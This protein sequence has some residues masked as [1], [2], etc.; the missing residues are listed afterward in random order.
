MF[1]HITIRASDRAAAERFYDTVLAP[2]AID[3][4]ALVRSATFSGWDDFAVTQ[5]DG[6]DDATTRLHVAFIARTQAEVHAFWEAGTA[7]GY[8]DDGAP[9][10][11][12]AYADDYYAA[13]LRDPDGNGIEAVYRD[14]PRRAEGIIDH[15]RLRVTDVSR[16]ADVYRR[17]AQV[18]GAEVRR[19]SPEM[20]LLA[21]A[22]GG[23]FS[24]IAD[25]PTR[26]AHIAFAADADAV[27]RFRQE[28]AAAGATASVL[29]PDGNRVEVADSRI[30][31][32]RS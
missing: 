19:D 17:V 5:A 26:N 27:A 29:D 12:P 2:L 20:L 6:P 9:G 31:Q 3:P 7:A 11:R 4:D 24:L 14:G 23:V 30:D 32:S 25:E 21:G 1:A 15:A 18:V 10:P 22:N 13:Y 8:A 16:S 28:A